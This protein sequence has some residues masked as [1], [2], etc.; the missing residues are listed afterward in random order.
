MYVHGRRCGWNAHLCTRLRGVIVFIQCYDIAFCFSDFFPSVI[1]RPITYA[2]NEIK[3]QLKDINKHTWVIAG[4]KGEV[5]LGMSMID[6]IQTHIIPSAKDLDTDV[7]QA[8]SSLGCFKDREKL[9]AAL[10][11]VE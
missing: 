6:V 11:S 2:N 9:T 1:V 7:L 4:G 10:L 3:L 8:I 5:H